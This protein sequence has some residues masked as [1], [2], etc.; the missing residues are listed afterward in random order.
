MDIIEDEVAE[1]VAQGRKTQF[2]KR[3]ILEAKKSP[4]TFVD[5]FTCNRIRPK[6]NNSKSVSTIRL[7]SSYLRESLK[8]GE[9]AKSEYDSEDFDTTRLT[10]CKDLAQN[11]FNLLIYGIGSKFSLLK[12][13]SVEYLSE[14]GDVIFINGA[15]GT[16]L[17][18]HIFGRVAQLL[19]KKCAGRSGQIP[20]RLLD[21]ANWIAKCMDELRKKNLETTI[22]LAI[23]CLDV[24]TFLD[25]NDVT[26][27]CKLAEVK[28]IRIAATI[29]NSRCFT[30]WDSVSLSMLG[31]VYLNLDTYLPY[32]KEEGYFIDQYVRNEDVKDRGLAFILKSLTT[33]HKEILK[34]LAEYQ[35]NS[36]KKAGLTKD[37]SV[38]YTHLT[39]PTNREV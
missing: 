21:Q 13:L 1:L 34:I 15:S 31:L 22:V 27:I 35:F 37:E 28:G 25:T 9:D 12:K 17:M 7:I 36:A 39:L 8:A 30:S 6:V 3:Q 20:S 33:R 14:V 24:I 23:H 4:L 5:Y 10:E 38:S 2:A 19:N 16:V 18:K 32:E 29:E 26:S 11:E